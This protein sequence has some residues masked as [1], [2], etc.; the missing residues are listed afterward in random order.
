MCEY[1]DG[2]CKSILDGDTTIFIFGYDS[3]FCADWGGDGYLDW[4][5]CPM[6]GRRL[7]AGADA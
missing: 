2:S 4:K 1:C 3:V 7:E 6:C 5:Y